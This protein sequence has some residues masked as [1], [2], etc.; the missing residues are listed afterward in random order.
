MLR[1][2]LLLY[3]VRRLPEK[4]LVGQRLPTSE[5]MGWSAASIL[6]E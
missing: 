2:T 6:Q 3:R 5:L 4:R 1:Q